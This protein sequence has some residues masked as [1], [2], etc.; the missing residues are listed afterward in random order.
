LDVENHEC[1][2]K[3]TNVE[4]VY[5]EGAIS[6][7]KICSGLCAREELWCATRDCQAEVKINVNGSCS[8]DTFIVE[9]LEGNFD[10]S[11]EH[12]QIYVNDKLVGKCDPGY[13]YTGNSPSWLSCGRWGVPAGD[14]LKVKIK[15]VN[16]DPIATYRGVS[17]AVYGKVTVFS[18]IGSVRLMGTGST[19]SEGNVEVLSSNGK[20]G[21]VCDDSWDLNDAKVVCRMLGHFEAQ[22]SGSGSSR[23]GLPS[24]GDNFVL[25]NVRCTGSES[26]IFDCTH[27]GEWVENCSGREIAAVR[28]AE[29]GSVRLMGTGSTA[30][31]GNVEVLSSNGKWGGVCDDYWSMN[32][33][34]V[35][36]RMLGYVEALWTGSGYG[37]Y[38][39]PSSGHKFVLDDVKCTG[40][41]STIFDC[42]H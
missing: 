12:I 19:A 6:G 3:E 9:V 22:W 25:D 31:K 29:I 37:T 27:R 21:G 8:S 15:S 11:A 23:Y 5:S 35:V 1:Q 14:Y 28:C 16:V 33:A 13:L 32:N 10:S 39:P 36:C 20:W 34:K 4:M 24:S 40:S 41:E 38:G 18:E 26:T 17:Y 30:S 2:L 7:S 42:T